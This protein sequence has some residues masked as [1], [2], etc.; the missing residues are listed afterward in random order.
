MSIIQPLKIWTCFNFLL[1]TGVHPYEQHGCYNRDRRVWGISLS[2]FFKASGLAFW[3]LRLAFAPF[4][5]PLFE[6]ICDLRLCK[7]T[8]LASGFDQYPHI[9]IFKNWI[10]SEPA[11]MLSWPTLC[12]PMGYSLLGFSVHEIL[13]ARMLEWVAISS[14]RGSSWPRDQIWFFCIAGSSFYY[15]STW[16][17]SEPGILWKVPPGF[18]FGKVEL[19]SLLAFVKYVGFLSYFF[20]SLL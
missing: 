16:E 19:F 9:Q 2:L 4:V 11:C 13:Q 3:G 18:P 6:T 10:S 12:D 8:F 5:L 7:C 17:S 15:W 20:I 14:F 1:V